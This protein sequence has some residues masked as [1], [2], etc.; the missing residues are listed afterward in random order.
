[1]GRDNEEFFTA[2]LTQARVIA[3]LRM[4]P[5]LSDRFNLR[6]SDDLRSSQYEADHS[7]ELR[8]DWNRAGAVT[9]LVDF[10]VGWMANPDARGTAPAIDANFFAAPAWPYLPPGAAGN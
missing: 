8:V 3:A 5:S 7:I 4:L 9:T 2:T 1:M 10:V 6:V